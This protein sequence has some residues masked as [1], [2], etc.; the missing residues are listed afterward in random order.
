MLDAGLTVIF[1]PLATATG[2]AD[3]IENME[4]EARVQAAF[5]MMFRKPGDRLFTNHVFWRPVPE[6]GEW[7]ERFGPALGDATIATNAKGQIVM[8]RRFTNYTLTLNTATKEVTYA[9]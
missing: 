8:T 4:I 7:P 5:G 6:W 1:I 2:G 9:P 3:T